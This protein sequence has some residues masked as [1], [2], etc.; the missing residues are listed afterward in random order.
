MVFGSHIGELVKG[1][2]TLLT[3]KSRESFLSEIA[4]SFLEQVKVYKNITTVE[5]VSAIKLDDAT[6]TN[7]LSLANKMAK[8]EVDLR[9]KVDPTL[10]GGFILRVG[11]QQVDASVSSEI[12][13]LRRQFEKNPFVAE[14]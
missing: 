6:R 4:A 1:F 14:L 2:M 13:D 5:V 3:S 12:R 9:E 8:G 7:V 11:D 10:I